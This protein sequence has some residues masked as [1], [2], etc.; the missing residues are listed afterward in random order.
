MSRKYATAF[1]LKVFCKPDTNVSPIFFGE[2]WFRL[3]WKERFK[4]DKENVVSKKKKKKNKKL[5]KKE[6]LQRYYWMFCE[7]YPFSSCMSSGKIFFS[8]HSNSD[9]NELVIWYVPFY[10]SKFQSHFNPC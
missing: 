4:T 1:S 2:D 6:N 5:K 9:F 3:D 10:N 8:L 7:D